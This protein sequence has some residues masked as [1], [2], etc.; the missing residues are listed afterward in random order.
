MIMTLL[1]KKFTNAYKENAASIV[2]GMVMM[3]G[4][5]SVY[6]MYRSLNVSDK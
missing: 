4:N 1:V 2:C 3:S 6:A 5:T